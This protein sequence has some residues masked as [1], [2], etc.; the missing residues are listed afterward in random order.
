[1]SHSF[2]V[3]PGTLSKL[4]RTSDPSHFDDVTDD[5]RLDISDSSEVEKQNQRLISLANMALG[6]MAESSLAN[7]KEF[8]YLIPENEQKNLIR[9]VNSSLKAFNQTYPIGS[10]ACS[11]SEALRTIQITNDFPHAIGHS[12]WQQIYHLLIQNNRIVQAGRGRGKFIVIISDRPLP[13]LTHHQEFET[14]DTTE[15]L[16]D[17]IVD[18]IRP[19]IYKLVKEFV[20]NQ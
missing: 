3:S 16:V 5:D 8:F 9:R 10:M 4:K 18:S 20:H 12:L 15:E 17:A 1:M 13:N 2:R 11:S 7:W 14:V 6:F 19:M